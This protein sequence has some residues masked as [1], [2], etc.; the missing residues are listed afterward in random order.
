MNKTKLKQLVQ[1]ILIFTVVLIIVG[2]FL[3]YKNYGQFNITNIFNEQTIYLLL[4][5]LLVN[6]VYQYFKK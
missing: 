3:Q 2:L 1:N 5:Y 4:G 6:I